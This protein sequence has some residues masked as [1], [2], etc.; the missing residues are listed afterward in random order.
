MHAPVRPP[1]R[2]LEPRSIFCLRTSRS[3]FR[4][5]VVLAMLSRERE[6][7]YDRHKA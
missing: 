2:A 6:H 3:A 7:K 4:R 5:E 1:H